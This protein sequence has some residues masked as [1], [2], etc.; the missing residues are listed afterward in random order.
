[1][2]FRVSQTIPFVIDP[3]GFDGVETTFVNALPYPPDL[4]LG[5]V[6]L[7]HAGIGV[8]KRVTGAPTIGEFKLQGATM[9]DV[10][11]GAAPKASEGVYGVQIIGS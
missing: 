1:M 11:F 9:R 5:E 10:V 6:H 4:E 7:T 2:S 8:L 3:A